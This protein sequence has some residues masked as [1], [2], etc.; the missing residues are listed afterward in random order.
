M[1]NV[2]D[3]VTWTTSSTRKVGR[4]WAIVQPGTRPENE[5]DLSKFQIR[6]A[7]DYPFPRDH[8][9]CL[10]EV[11]GGLRSR[12]SIYWPVTQQLVLV[13]GNGAKIDL[14][15]ISRT[16]DRLQVSEE[17]SRWAKM[18]AEDQLT[19]AD[20]VRKLELWMKPGWPEALAG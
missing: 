15:R 8:K 5:H 20:F 3:I 7:T 14:S 4:V 13:R 2:G 18:G 11:L 12:H 9:S 16:A 6:F 19:D 17:I 1:L 10:V